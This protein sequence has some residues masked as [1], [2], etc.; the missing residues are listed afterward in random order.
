[1]IILTKLNNVTFALNPDLIETIEE[2]PDTTIKLIN[3][4]IILVRESMNEVIQKIIEFRVSTWDVIDRVRLANQLA[5]L[6]QEGDR[7]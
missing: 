4:N 2:N 6:K 5:E 3:K 1:M 7:E